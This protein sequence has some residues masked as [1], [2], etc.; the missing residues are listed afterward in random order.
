ML[1][2]YLNCYKNQQ[3]YGHPDHTPSDA[4][5]Q[6]DEGISGQI[7]PL[8]WV[9]HAAAGEKSGNA[10]YAWFAC[11]AFAF[12][13]TATVPQLCDD[14]CRRPHLLL[15]ILHSSY[16]LQD[17]LPPL[18]SW[19]QFIGSTDGSTADFILQ[20]RSLW[21]AVRLPLFIVSRASMPVQNSRN[22]ADWT[23]HS[24]RSKVC[25]CANVPWAFGFEG[26][27]GTCI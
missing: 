26:A 8:W 19:A 17:L 4:D 14:R 3:P 18:G 15:Y 25:C 2:Q 9:I 13:R 5:L 16:S 12:V 10:A 1:L 6:P 24:H 27:D 23:M 21:L 11:W 22:P 20:V 7:C